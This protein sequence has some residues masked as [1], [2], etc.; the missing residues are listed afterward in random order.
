MQDLR[1]R[2]WRA[3]APVRSSIP[4]RRGTMAIIDPSPTSEEMEKL[5]AAL[6]AVA[7][8]LAAYLKTPAGHADAN[9]I[10]LTTAALDIYAEADNISFAQLQLGIANGGQAVDVIN[11][12]MT[13]I[14]KC[15]YTRYDIITNLEI[16]Q[17]VARLTAAIAGGAVAEIIASGSKLLEAL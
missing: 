16:M 2:M 7:N 13:Q 9:Y 15:L 14:Q 5:E 1:P 8:K 3:I 4:A 17:S 10:Q 6:T 12:A 11:N